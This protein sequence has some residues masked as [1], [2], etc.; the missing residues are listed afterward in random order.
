MQQIVSACVQ[1]TM[2]TSCDE[3]EISGVVGMS[4]PVACSGRKGIRSGSRHHR[5]ADTQDVTIRTSTIQT[6][7][8]LQPLKQVFQGM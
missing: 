8:R 7:V 1:G 5:F 2:W 6:Q 4:Q 3:L